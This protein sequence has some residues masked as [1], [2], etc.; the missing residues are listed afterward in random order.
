MKKI[1]NTSMSIGDAIG[2]YALYLFL[3]SMVLLMFS[4]CISLRGARD[5]F[6]RN[7]NDFADLSAQYFPCLPDSAGKIPVFIRAHNVDYTGTL[8]SLKQYGDSLQTEFAKAHKYAEDSISRRC[9]DLVASYNWQVVRLTTALDSLRR[10]YR[11][12]RPDSVP[13][14]Y[15]VVSKAELEQIRQLQAINAGQKQRIEEQQKLI[16]K[17]F[18]IQGVVVIAFLLWLILKLKR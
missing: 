7:P 6:A 10:S 2:W 17:L 1:L 12:P 16:T 14:P 5:M 4:G 11:P 15:Q 9:A 18:I 3:F 13:V 8:D